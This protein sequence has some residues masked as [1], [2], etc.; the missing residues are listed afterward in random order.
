MRNPGS[1][2]NTHILYQDRIVLDNTSRSTE[3]NNSTVRWVR[4]SIVSDDAV[5]TTETD[6]VGPLLE[7]VGAAWAD[8]VVLNDD[9]RARERSLRDVK[10][11][12]RAWVK[13][14]NVFNLGT[15]LSCMNYGPNLEVAYQ[16][17]RVT[18]SHLNVGASLGRRGARPGSIN[19]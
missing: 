13:R 17:P 4:N 2:E 11:R 15:P 3:D 12:P 5:G 19:L 7:R 16:L 6:A 18:S 10:A 14:M 1:D 8:I 9:A